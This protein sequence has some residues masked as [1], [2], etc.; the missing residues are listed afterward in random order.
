MTV[1]PPLI[2]VLE[3]ELVLRHLM[4]RERVEPRIS[5]VGG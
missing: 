4:I 3:D 2:L 1:Q 5:R